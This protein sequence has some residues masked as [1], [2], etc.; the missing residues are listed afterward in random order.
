MKKTSRESS[1]SGPA[2]AF[3]WR[4]LVLMVDPEAEAALDLEALAEV[5]RGREN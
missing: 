4:A 2:T 5:T 1:F 3:L